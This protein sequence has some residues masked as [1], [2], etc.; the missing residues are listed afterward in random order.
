MT[1]RKITA[2]QLFAAIEKADAEVHASQQAYFIAD[3]LEDVLIDGR[4]NLRRVAE[5]LN[6]RLIA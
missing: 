4:V 2:E 6:A 1:E 5:I 3:D